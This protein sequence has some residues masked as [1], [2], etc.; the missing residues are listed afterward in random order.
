M[1]AQPRLLT[2]F[3]YPS[4]LAL[5]RIL[6][7]TPGIAI[8]TVIIYFSCLATKTISGSWALISTTILVVI[9]YV[10]IVIISDAVVY[11]L[12]M[13][14]HDTGV[15]SSMCHNKNAIGE[16]GNGKSPHEFKFSRKTQSPV[17]GF[18][19]PPNRICSTVFLSSSLFAS[20][21]PRLLP[22][23]NLGNPCYSCFKSSASAEFGNASTA[24]RF[25]HDLLI[26]VKV[27][28]F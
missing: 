12:S 22:A 26:N 6:G 16:E 7:P 19:D 28:S 20:V 1:L 5:S 4:F 14:T 3:T 25:S 8:S 9:K 21:Q 18:C 23:F 11:W 15:V 13:R 27:I 17:S 10:I 2:A 24:T